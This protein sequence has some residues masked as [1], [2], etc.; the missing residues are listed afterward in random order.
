VLKACRDTGLF[1]CLTNAFGEQRC[2]D[3]IV[4]ASYIIREGNAM[5]G[6]D[7]WLQRNHVPGYDRTLNSQ[8]TS[9]LFAGITAAE[10][11][12]FF[13]QWIGKALGGGSVFYDV[14]SISSYARGMI[15]VERGY[16]RDGD[17]LDQFN[18]GMFCDKATKLPLYYNRYNGSLTDKANLAYVVANAN[19]VGITKISMVLDGGFW[20]DECFRSLKDHCAAFT[21]GMPG[22]LK[23]SGRIIAEHGGDIENYVNKLGNCHHVYCKQIA[24]EIY[25]VGGRVLLYYDSRNHTSLCDELSEKIDNLSL[26]LSQLKRYPQG[27]LKRY[28]PYFKISKHSDGGGFDY[29][30]DVE[31]IEKLRKNKGYFLLFTTDMELS[32]ADILSYYRAK[33]A[34]EKLFA[35]IKV[36]LG[37]ARV[38][39]HTSETTDGK[40]FATFIACLIRSHIANK[41]SAYLAD[42]STSLKKVFNQLSNITVVSSDGGY[43]FTKALTKKQKQILLT[44]G[45][46]DA[47]IG[48][49]KA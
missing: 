15:E 16:N 25:G 26:E 29:V 41:L 17:D 5:D 43:R 40:M 33:D 39:T 14:T 28:S 2:M 32:P 11:H 36:E 19:T 30:I 38:R 48:S 49:L 31:K 44:F 18:I 23:E 7:D 12:K 6:I 4:M 20:S 42:S 13:K 24:A 27:K 21:V 46:S 45:L 35:Q 1:D 37:G 47:I 3:I 10:R 8:A 22:F 9:K 34:D